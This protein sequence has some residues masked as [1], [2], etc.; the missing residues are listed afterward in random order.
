MKT[1]RSMLF[2]AIILA[3]FMV[4]QAVAQSGYSVNDQIAKLKTELNLNQEQSKKVALLLI[5][6]DEK[7]TVENERLA[8]NPEARRKASRKRRLKLNDEMKLILDKDQYEKFQKMNLRSPSQRTTGQIK[9]LTEALALTKKQVEKVQTIYDKY[10]PELEQIFQSFR[11]GDGNTDRQANRARMVEIREKMSSE[12]KAV[13]IKE[14]IG[15]YEK[16]LEENRERGRHRGRPG[17]N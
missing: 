6:M 4:G 17:R 14:Q 13:L 10:Q 3:M 8:D 11:G 5:K 12:I 1:V 2:A 9:S 15:K 16:Y 7:Q